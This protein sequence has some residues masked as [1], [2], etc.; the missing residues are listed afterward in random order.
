M[1]AL[2]ADA[3]AI[4]LCVLYMC[5]MHPINGGNLIEFEIGMVLS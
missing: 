5:I 3:T 4:E 1:I 2:R